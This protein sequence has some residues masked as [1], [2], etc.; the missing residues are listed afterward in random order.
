MTKHKILLNVETTDKFDEHGMA[1]H[2]ALTDLVAGRVWSMDGVKDVR[3]SRLD[4]ESTYYILSEAEYNELQEFKLM[5][6]GIS[7]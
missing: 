4:G 1:G 7:K 3:A 6:E 5:Y 2:D